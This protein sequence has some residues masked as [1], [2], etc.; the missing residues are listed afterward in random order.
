MKKLDD[1]LELLMGE[2][3]GKVLDE[4]GS[5]RRRSERMEEEILSRFE[6]SDREKVDR[7]W[8]NPYHPT[9]GLPAVLLRGPGGWNPVSAEDTERLKAMD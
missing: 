7:C 9:I 8:R 5:R 4:C 3:I 1:E 6:E 2:R